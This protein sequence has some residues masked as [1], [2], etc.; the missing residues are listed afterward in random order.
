MTRIGIAIGGA[1]MLCTSSVVAQDT[2]PVILGIYFRC[3]QAQETNADQVVRTTLAPIV[4]KH[5]TAGHLTGWV[6]LNHN[7][8]GPWRRVF[9]ILGTDLNQMMNVRQEITDE[10]TTRHADAANR[11]STACASHDDYIWTGVSTSVPNPN[12]LGPAS[13]SAYHVCDRSREGRADEIF[14]QVLAPLYKKHADMGHITTWGYYA[15]RMGGIFRRLETFAGPDHVTLMNMQNAIYEEAGT[16]HP[17]AMREFNE[18]C[19]WH[20]D[21]MWMNQT[22]Q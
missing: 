12:A 19:S 5:V 8:G 20:T 3:N 7:Q 1:M 15:H 18:I 4:R 16:T 22:P 21:Y 13:I 2:N 11:L 14:T 10:F 9:A 6:W 17:L